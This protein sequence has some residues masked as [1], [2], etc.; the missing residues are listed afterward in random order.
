LS[1]LVQPDGADALARFNSE[2]DLVD[3]IARQ[4]SRSVGRLVEFDDLLS[5]GREGLLDAARRYDPSRD[6]SFRTYANHRIRGA[7]LD[8]VRKLAALPRRAFERLAAL[9]VANRIDEAEVPFILANAGMSAGEADAAIESQLAIT[10]SACALATLSPDVILALEE[11]PRASQETP[12]EQLARA[13]LLAHLERAIG[14]IKEPREAEVLRLHYFEGMTMDAI[15]AEL[16]TDKSWVSR[17]HRRGL[18][19]LTRRMRNIV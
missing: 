12:E 16:G 1:D 6:I 19:R 2:L 11:P 7:M 5:A 9:A 3:L 4:V 14:E 17:L 8:N 15:A 18:D 10:A 13:E